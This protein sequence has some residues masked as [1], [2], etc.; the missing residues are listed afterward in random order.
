MWQAEHFCAKS[1]LPAS[2]VPPARLIAPPPAAAALFSVSSHLLKAA[3]GSITSL[4]RIRLWS[5]PQNSEQA[6]SYI[7]ARSGV[8]LRFCTS[9]G[10][11]AALS[12]I[13]GTQN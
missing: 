2:A 8:K 12:R 4:P 3:T 9:P 6:M 11:A 13:S 1:A 7:P 10:T 5:G